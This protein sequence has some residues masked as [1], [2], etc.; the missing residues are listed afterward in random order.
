MEVRVLRMIET[1]AGRASGLLP[2]RPLDHLRRLA[3]AGHEPALAT[4]REPREPELQH[5]VTVV[6]NDT[7]EPEAPKRTGVH[8]L[9]DVAG[10]AGRDRERER[11]SQ[12]RRGDGR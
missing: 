12:R 7:R 5:A 11:E 3:L 2:I 9:V 10:I 8:R 1:G 6:A 4:G